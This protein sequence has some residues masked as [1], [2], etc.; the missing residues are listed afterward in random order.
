MKNDS[1]KIDGM[2]FGAPPE[3]FRNARKLRENMTEPELILW[4]LLKRKPLGFKFRRQ[5]PLHLYIL[6]FYCHAKRL[7]IEIDGGYHAFSDQKIKDIDRTAFL[8]S[9]EIKEIR[10][11]NKE[12]LQELEKVMCAIEHELR[13]DTPLGAG[14]RWGFETRMLDQITITLPSI[15]KGMPRPRL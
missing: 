8:N 2:H 14:E 6:D 13:A 7:S 3:I 9:V 12:V 1:L 15:P 10:F 5:H 4:N 11:K